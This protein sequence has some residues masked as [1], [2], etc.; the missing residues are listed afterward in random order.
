MTTGN[1]PDMLRALWQ[2]QPDR[3]F[4]MSSDEI[5]KK[6]EQLQAR[7]RRRTITVYVICLGEILWF[8]YWLIFSSLPVMLRVGSL[9]IIL[10]MNFVAGQIWLD[11]RDR[12]KTMQS[13]NVAAQANCVDFY[14]CELVRQRDFH[15]G[16]WFW[17]RLFALLP[18]LL[19]CGAWAAIRLHGTR[20]GYVGDGILIMTAILCALAIWLNYRVS[21]KHQKLIDAID[22]MK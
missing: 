7:L 18:G 3:S 19:I 9:L 16:A 13:A 6:L 2:K 11:D 1:D 14:R 15:R 17:S 8:A 4:S 21:R 20:D 12:R 5:E 22:A 10:A